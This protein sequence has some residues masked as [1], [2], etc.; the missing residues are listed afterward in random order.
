[1]RTV[2]LHYHIYKNAGTSFDHVLTHNFGDRHELFDGPYP[3]F[4]IDQ[5]QL[6]RIIMRR[7]QAVA[8][9]SHQILLPPPSSIGY[10]ALA[11][12]FLRNPFLRIASI[13]RF[14]RG[15]ERADGTP[16]GSLVP[17]EL[18]AELTRQAAEAQRTVNPG[19]PEGTLPLPEPLPAPDFDKTTTAMAARR[20]D[21]AGWIEHCLNSPAEV[22]HVSN[23]QTR[24]FASPYRTRP[25][26]KRTA[27]G[28]TYD[29]GTALR[30]LA[31]IELL[32]RTEQFEADVARFGDILAGHGLT[33]SLPDD[34]RH[35]VTDA[36]PDSTAER[37]EAMLSALPPAL[38][39][40][41]IRA[42]W[43]DAALYDRACALIAA[44][45][46]I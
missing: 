43:Q 10:R 15:P 14:K 35:N 23:A 27:E 40:R 16:L 30:T 4:T 42:N 33:L 12:I 32:G 19:L 6:D 31:G 7:P 44:D 21:L 36:A 20:H 9:S 38:R 28:I 34:T 11:A 5:D 26:L 41:L 25:V 17:E 13:Y 18:E 37:V 46:R 3:F 22:V 39:D 24:F 8:F 29:L 2:I 1:M 45:H